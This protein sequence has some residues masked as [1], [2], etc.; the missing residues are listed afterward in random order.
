MRTCFQS[1]D[2]A[3]AAVAAKQLYETFTLVTVA[4][5]AVSL[6]SELHQ[7]TFHPVIG[8]MA[9]ARSLHVGQSRL[10]ERARDA[11]EALVVWDVGLGAAA[12]AVAVLEEWRDSREPLHLHSFDSTLEPLSFASAHAAELGY[13]APWRGAIETLRTKGSVEIGALRW[14]LH[15]G[16]FRNLVQAAPPEAPHAIL[17]D[18]YSPAANPGM[19]TVEHF[20]RVRAALDSNRP[21]SLTSYSRS[22]AVRVTLAL[23]GFYPGRGSSTGEK[24]E[25]TVAATHRE[26]LM[27]PLDDGWLERVRRSTRGG[28]LREGIECGPISAEDLA[29]LEEFLAEKT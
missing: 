8:P 21:C 9:E 3:C 26:L 6:R 7:E 11:N 20:R 23:A 29:A 13:L 10:R 4:S 2:V 25:T 18:P 17:Y 1:S 16:D 12:N 27:H 19:W 15:L 22:T 14:M 24:D 5:G 28:P